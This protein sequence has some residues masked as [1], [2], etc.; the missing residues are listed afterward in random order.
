MN[1]MFTLIGVAAILFGLSFVGV[2]IILLVRKV[3]RIRK[4]TKTTGVVVNVEAH[5]GMYQDIGRTRNTLYKPTVRFQTADGRVID[6]TPNTSNSWSNYR[7]GENVPVYYDPQ[8]PEK[9]IVGT[10]FKLWFPFF[11]FGF[12]GGIFSLVG[13]FF[14]LISMNLP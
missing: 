2:T 13:A 11:L 3:L 5:E 14:V 6:Y 8:Q 10:T 9:A 1:Q 7:V 12:A 4:S